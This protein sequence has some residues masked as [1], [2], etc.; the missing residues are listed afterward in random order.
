MTFNCKICGRCCHGDGE[1]FLYPDD[2]RRLA[3]A[4]KMTV[5]KFVDRYTRHIMFEIKESMSS[6]IYIPYLVL[7]KEDGHCIMLKDEKCSV[8]AD[9]P[10]H[11]AVTPFTEELYI[12]KEWREFITDFCPALKEMSPK[13]IDS[14]KKRARVLSKVEDS[15]MGLLE[16][17]SYSLELILNIK[18]QEPE[19]FKSQE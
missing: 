1:A 8:H 2:I 12:D 10:V 15:Y 19:V 17:N 3:T 5:Q 16:N 18:L 6:Y 11:C 14:M 9:K 13:E 4:M 7:K